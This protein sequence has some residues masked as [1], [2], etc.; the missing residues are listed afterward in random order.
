MDVEFIEAGIDGKH[1]I[2]WNISNDYAP[3]R[4]IRKV[5]QFA[6]LKLVLWITRSN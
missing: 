4:G 5:E 1:L 3:N 6:S 2:M